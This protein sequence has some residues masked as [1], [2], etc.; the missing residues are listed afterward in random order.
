[1]IATLTASHALFIPSPNGPALQRR[2]P[3]E[4]VAPAETEEGRVRCKRELDDGHLPAALADQSDAPQERLRPGASFANGTE[5]IDPKSNL[6]FR[7]S[8]PTIR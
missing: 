7:T 2:G 1:M 8:L 5:R 4:I 3:R 6:R